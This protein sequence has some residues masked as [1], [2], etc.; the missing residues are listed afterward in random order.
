[1][2]HT[3]V[4][5]EYRQES[6]SQVSMPGSPSCGIVWKIHFISPVRASKPRTWPGGADCRIPLSCTIEPTTTV[7]P[8]MAG[9]ELWVMRR[10]LIRRPNI[11]SPL[12]GRRSTTPPS[13]N[14]ATGSPVLAFRATSLLS[15]V[16]MKILR[17]APS[18][19]YATP[20]CWNPTLAGRPAF[21]ASGSCCHTISP[22]AAS[23]AAT[24]E[25]SEA[26]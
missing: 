26:T 7:S 6:F 8:A 22:V 12:S 24:C 11:C 15:W 23:R 10:L 14:V 4:A 2:L 5:P 3:L 20:R 13:P 17:S 16:A 1:M 25:I 9:G 18:A 21:H 19:Q